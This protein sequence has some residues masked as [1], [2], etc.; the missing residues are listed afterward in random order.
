MGIV[1]KFYFVKV[2]EIMP[3]DKFCNIFSCHRFVSRSSAQVIFCDGS[4]W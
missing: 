3:R 4:M 2:L 1:V